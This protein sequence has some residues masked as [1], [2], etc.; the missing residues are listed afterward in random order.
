ME[1]RVLGC[2]GAELLQ[3]RSCSFL[4]NQTVL[5]D[6]GSI[7]TVLSLPEQQGLRAILLSHVHSDHIK[8]L[9]SLLENL[10]GEKDQH[11]ITIFGIEEVITSLNAHLF[12]DE[13]WPDHL[14]ISGP[15]GP[16][17]QM[18]T[19]LPNT[20]F[21]VEGLEITPILS[22]H[23][24]PCTGFMIRETDRAFLYSGDTCETEQLW[25]SAAAEPKLKAAFIEVS[26][27]NAMKEIARQSKHLTPDL[28]VQE[29]KKIGKPNLPLY[30]YHMKP[31]YLDTLRTE[32][33]ETGIRHLT[34]LED[35]MRIQ[36]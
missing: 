8:G 6:A 14:K 12:N 17:F 27:P 36:I 35:D 10:V 22:N 24:V 13:I 26:F 1:V 32:L 25:K 20:P 4:I 23:T 28:L 19:I 31:R 34:I 29:F 2:H 11:P 16:L 7:S 15:Q 30:A 21:S 9:P 3:K 33:N 5:L 18:R